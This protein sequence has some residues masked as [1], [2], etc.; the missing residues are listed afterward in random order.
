MHLEGTKRHGMG[1]G[2]A[3]RKVGKYIE[4]SK[5]SLHSHARIRLVRRKKK[6]LGKNLI[7]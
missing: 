2:I 3:I 6:K 1:M 7:H 5:S 4:I